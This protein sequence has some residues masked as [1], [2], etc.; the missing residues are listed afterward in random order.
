MQIQNSF[1]NAVHK[2]VHNKKL[3][4]YKCSFFYIYIIKNKNSLVNSNVEVVDSR[5][6]LQTCNSEQFCLI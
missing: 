6:I 2:A 1:L 5:I 4:I 3:R